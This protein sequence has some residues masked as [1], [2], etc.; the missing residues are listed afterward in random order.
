ME[1]RRTE[2]TGYRLHH[3]FLS[4]SWFS[5]FYAP[6][7]LFLFYF[8]PIVRA[9]L[10]GGGVLPDFLSIFFCL[11]LATVGKVIFRTVRINVFMYGHPS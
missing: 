10:G 9:A 4:F 7:V 11:G 6:S 3:L 2:A 5:L 8:L 1:A